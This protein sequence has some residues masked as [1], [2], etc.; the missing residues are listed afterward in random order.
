MSDTCEYDGTK[1]TLFY[2]RPL[3]PDEIMTLYM[4]ACDAGSY[5]YKRHPY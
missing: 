1:L 4:R 5:L 3:T 2:H